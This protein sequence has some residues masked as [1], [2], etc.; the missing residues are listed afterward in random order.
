MASPSGPIGAN[1]KG[2]GQDSNLHHYGL[3][4]D[5]PQF[6]SLFRQ[7]VNQRCKDIAICSTIELP[8]P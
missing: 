4:V 1:R 3:K 8:A 2:A 7:G 5:N 6:F